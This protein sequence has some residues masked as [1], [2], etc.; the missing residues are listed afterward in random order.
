MLDP[1]HLERRIA[2]ALPS[3]FIE[4]VDTTGTGDHFRATVV[5]EAFVGKTLVEQHQMVY[6]PLRADLDSGV[7]HALAVVTWTPEQWSKRAGGDK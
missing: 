4:V 5:S 3:S 2:E 1:K 6:A 7:L